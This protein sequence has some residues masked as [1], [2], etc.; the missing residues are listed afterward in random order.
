MKI[1]RRDDFGQQSVS[2]KI[3]S[4]T[5]CSNSSV[6]SEF[7]FQICS[8]KS[9][10]LSESPNGTVVKGVTRLRQESSYP[11]EEINFIDML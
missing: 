8:E 4:E 10:L 5:D 11:R 1:T 3:L 7:V 6:S 2:D 9:G